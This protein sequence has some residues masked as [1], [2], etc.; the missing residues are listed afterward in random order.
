MRV[1]IIIII[2]FLVVITLKL[3][4]FLLQFFLKSLVHI[5]TYFTIRASSFLSRILKLLLE[6]S[7]EI[8]GATKSWKP[9]MDSQLPEC[10]MSLPRGFDTKLFYY[11][12]ATTDSSSLPLS[13]CTQL[14]GRKEKLWISALPNLRP[15][16]HVG[17]FFCVEVEHCGKFLPS[18]QWA[19]T[20]GT[21]KPQMISRIR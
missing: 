2:I 8:K 7:K 20:E 21:K 1:I 3:L 17:C 4:I 14:L 6:K 9:L 11:P 16:R 13:S 18:N 5:H 19:R 12:G 10:S 15:S